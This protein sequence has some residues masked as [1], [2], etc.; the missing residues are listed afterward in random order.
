MDYLAIPESTL[1]DGTISLL[2]GC[3]PVLRFRWGGIGNQCFRCVNTAGML[4]SLGSNGA[5]TTA[6]SR[7]TIME[8]HFPHHFCSDAQMCVLHHGVSGR[9]SVKN[10]ANGLRCPEMEHLMMLFFCCNFLSVKSP[11]FNISVRP[12]GPLPYKRDLRSPAHSQLPL[13]PRSSM[14]CIT[15]CRAVASLSLILE[16]LDGVLPVKEPPPLGSGS[17]PPPQG[18]GNKA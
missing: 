18:H 2:T 5:H 17:P 11:Q 9:I 14:D 8:V 7:H 16:D 10:L 13:T 12:Q 15:S 1:F 4:T 6:H 3:F